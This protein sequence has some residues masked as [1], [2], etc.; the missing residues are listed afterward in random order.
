MLTFGV[1]FRFMDFFF[2]A[3][4]HSWV[5]MTK[6]A[7]GN[8]A[9]EGENISCYEHTWHASESL[10]LSAWESNNPIVCD[11]PRNLDYVDAV[12][13]SFSSIFTCI[14]GRKRRAPV[15]HAAAN[16]WINLNFAYENRFL[17][18]LVEFPGAPWSMSSG[19]WTPFQSGFEV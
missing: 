19:M 7:S 6:T 3:E 17:N 1:C 11:S 5:N 14:D 9:P 18:D 8:I 12:G 2:L 13:K 4:S 15:A 16:K 10:K